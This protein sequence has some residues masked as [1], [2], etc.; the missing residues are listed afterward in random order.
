MSPCYR[1]SEFEEHSDDSV[2][3]RVITP[4]IQAIPGNDQNVSLAN[5]KTAGS[6]LDRR[7]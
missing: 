3:T 2:I 7:S 6:K 1:L 5:H 4:N